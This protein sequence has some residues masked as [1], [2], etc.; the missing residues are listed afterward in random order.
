MSHTPFSVVK[1]K[2]NARS[3]VIDDI[4]FQSILEGACYEVIRD[5]GITYEMQKPFILQPKFEHN[6]KKIQPI[7]YVCDFYV[8]QGDQVYVLDAKGMVLPL[9][10]MKMKMMLYTTGHHI[11]CVGSITKMKKVVKM[12]ADR[13]SPEDIIQELKPKKRPKKK[14]TT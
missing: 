5:S 4:K 11:I 2:Y 10:K 14:T 9:F 3:C 12:I 6:G 8:Q 1:S 7:K 13:L